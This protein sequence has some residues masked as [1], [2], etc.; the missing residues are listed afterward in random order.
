MSTSENALPTLPGLTDEQVQRMFPFGLVMLASVGSQS[1]GTFIAKNDP[2]SIDDIDLMGVYVSPI[3]GYFGFGRQETIERKFG[4][5]GPYDVVSYD[6]RHFVALLMKSNP[7]VLG[8]LWMK[9]EHILHSSDIAETLRANRSLFAT[10]HAYQSFAGYAKGQLHRMTHFDGPARKK[11]QQIEEELD[12]RAI[13]PN[14]T[15]E[16]LLA[17]RPDLH[18]E[19]GSL[20]PGERADRPFMN[21]RGSEL[22]E[23][24]RQMCNKYT[25][26]Y[27]GKKRRELVERFG[28]DVKNAAHLLRLL[29]MSIE[30]LATGELHVDRTGIDA[31][32]LMEV[33]RGEWPLEKVQRVA[34]A[35][36]AASKAADKWSQLPERPNQH[37]IETLLV[38]LLWSHFRS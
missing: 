26:G 7:N 28:Y 1:H 4:E 17:T 35:L 3:E 6:L 18:A 36:F 14:L 10:R 11:M 23:T 31:Q 21:I 38:E 15:P 37:E 32:E 29:K 20:K 12:R 8:M 24:Y 30:F 16:E 13:P 9:P 19:P 27:M 2:D 22:L 34:E 25:S 33:K 5:Y